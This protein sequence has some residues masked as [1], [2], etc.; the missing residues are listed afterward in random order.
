AHQVV[1]GAILLVA[2]AA[3]WWARAPG[4]GAGGDETTY[5]VLS[6]SLEHGRYHDEF[7]Q[8]TPPHAKYPP[9]T[10]LWLA[11]VRWTAGSSLDA[12]QAANLL[13]LALTALMLGDAVRRL[14]GP[15]PGVAAVGLSAMSPPLLQL[16]G[17]AV[18]EVPFTFLAVA[19]LWL[20]LLADRDRRSRGTAAALVAALGA[21]L[22]RSA[23]IA[24]V[25]G[26][27]AWILMRRRWRP[28]LG[29][30]LLSA[31][32]VGGWFAYAA[33]AGSTSDPGSSYA[34]DMS[35]VGTAGRGGIGG[36]FLQAATNAKE[37][38]LMLPQ[39][40]A[41]P[42]LP[43]TL[44]DN[45]IWLVILGACGTMGMVVFLRRWP[46]AAVHLVLS[47]AVLLAWPWPLP[48]LIV[49]MLPL[50]AAAVLTGAFVIART[51]GA[52]AQVIVPLAL[53]ALLGVPGLLA[54][55]ATDTN[56]LCDRRN[57]G[58]ESVCFPEHSAGMVA[59][60]RWISDTAPPGAVIA[61]TKPSTVF[62]FSGHRTMPLLSTARPGR[63]DD[64]AE[65][66]AK[67]IDWI[68]L[69]QVMRNERAIANEWLGGDCQRLEVR[70]EI[71]QGA[72]LLSLRAPPG[73][74]SDACDA[75]RRFVLAFP[76]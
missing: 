57:P 48:R 63:A 76:D 55:T 41:V 10:P 59:A 44:I 31:V 45:L 46:A 23:G 53:A 68:L 52:R 30:L 12:V 18:S 27:I 29:A 58:Y 56:H 74:G 69:S 62:Y 50:V 13:L 16:A 54:F 19:A 15:W 66:G 67:G 2:V 70:A 39:S 25:A 26:I 22:T 24:T 6:R 11:M 37:Y 3:G 35:R 43:G 60:A 51:I 71:P 32:V 73:S 38:V 33:R 49:P 36:L 5:L 47:F 8:G 4:V 64:L 20:T 61:T 40:L 42:L 28:A 21:F 14:T 75:I 34:R 72:L 17:S 9:G 1:I 7:L 65:I